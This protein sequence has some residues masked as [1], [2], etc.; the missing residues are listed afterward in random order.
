MIALLIRSQSIFTYFHHLVFNTSR[1]IIARACRKR[2]TTK[3]IKVLTQKPNKRRFIEFYQ[4]PIT[5]FSFGGVFMSTKNS[6][7]T[8]II[9]NVNPSPS[10][11]FKETEN[12]QKPKNW[13]LIIVLCF[14]SLGVLGA[15]LKYLEDD[16]NKQKALPQNERS[17]LSKINPFFTAPP[18]SP[19]PQLSKEYIYAGGKL[20]AVE[21][22]NANAAPPA[23]L[24]IWRPSTG[25]WWVMG[26]SGSQQVSQSW[27]TNGD[28]PSEGDYDGDG[29]TDFCVFRP[30]TNVWWIMRSSDGSYYS[31]TFGTNGDKP[32][33]ADF[34]GD[35]KTDI[36]VF[37][38]SNATWYINQSSTTNTIAI[39]FGG[40]SDKPTPADFDGD[41]KADV[42]TWRNSNNTFYSLNSSNAQ[43]QTTSY[44]T[45]D[46]VPVCGD[47]DG[48][49]RADVAV[50]RTSN[51]TWY[52][53]NSSNGNTVSY[54]WGISTDLPVQND[55]DADGKVDM[56]LWRAVNSGS[57]DVGKWFIYQSA[58][59]TIRQEQWGISNDIPVPSYYRR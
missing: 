50:W 17:L 41:G 40:G 21:D 13:L 54:Q 11:D 8:N 39:A 45:T 29:K 9:A 20:L 33:Q 3:N 1:L 44:G 19:T 2:K 30:S 26:G 5:S 35:G 34:D 38:P 4:N 42:A 56:A 31:V 43:T 37:R 32:A 36:A 14:L 55:Y 23:D 58:T 7:R 48:D 53:K 49:G 52:Y 51:N 59:G 27:G 28:D 46:D 24:A 16:A 15:G 12:S 22:K 6:K 10:R 57:G 18:P 47:Y 25:T